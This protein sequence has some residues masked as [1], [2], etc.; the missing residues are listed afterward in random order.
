M[1]FVDNRGTTDAATNLALEEWVLRHAPAD[2]SHL[3]LYV[4]A[5]S[6]VIGRNQNPA[7]E[8]N[9]PYVREH[10][11]QVVRRM[12]GGG[13][14]YHDLGNLN[15]S[16][17]APYAPE[18][19]NRYEEFTRPV[20]EVLRELGVPAELNARNDI[21]VGDR[22]ISGNAQSMAAGRMFSH[23]TVLFCSDLDRVSEALRVSPTGRIESKSVKS[24]RSRVANVRDFLRE[25]ITIE[26]FRSRI[27]ERALGSRGAPPTLELT[28]A[29]WAGVRELRARKYATWEWNYGESPAFVVERRTRTA[30]GEVGVRV[31]VSRRGR[32]EE[33]HVFGDLTHPGEVGELRRR[34]TGVR[35]ERCAIAAA[36]EELPSAAHF[37]G[38][39]REEVLALL[40][41]A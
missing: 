11:I 1:K 10:G 5:P 33:L 29:D 15:F 26:E 28:E 8:V 9:G 22:K 18:R 2:E 35:F 39:E 41:A 25:P 16:F 3:L 21:V 19:F 23:G 24:V 17:Q 4:N 37:G 40:E 31:S 13:A 27:V 34:L 20:I 38:L 32:I 12:S 6:V 14:V 7:E 30:S 36:L